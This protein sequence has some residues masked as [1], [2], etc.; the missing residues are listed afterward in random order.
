MTCGFLICIY[1]VVTEKITIIS[2]NIHLIAFSILSRNFLYSQTIIFSKRLLPLNGPLRKHAQ[3]QNKKKKKKIFYQCT[4]S[5]F[6]CLVQQFEPP[7]E[8][9]NNLHM[10]KQ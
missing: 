9:T 7:H 3:K 4:L 10:R 6:L 8:K 5:N 2:E 1:A